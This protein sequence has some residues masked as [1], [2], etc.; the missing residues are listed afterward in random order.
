[1]KFRSLVT[2]Q[3]TVS[4]MTLCAVIWILWSTD[5]FTVNGFKQQEWHFIVS[6]DSRNCGDVVMP[7]IASHSLRYAPAFYCLDH[8]LSD[9][10][11]GNTNWKIL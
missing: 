7:T 5:L 1:V 2:L 10:L 9:A 11:G 4:L 8:V 6:G 3:F